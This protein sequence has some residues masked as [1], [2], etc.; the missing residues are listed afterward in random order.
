MNAN[1]RRTHDAIVGH[2]APRDIIW[3]D[4]IHMWNDLADEVENESGDRLSVTMNGHREVFRRGHDG[5]VGIED[6][7]RARHL[8]KATPVDQGHGSLY[9][10]TVDDE[11]AHL[12]EFDLDS[13]KVDADEQQVTDGDRRARRLRTT[14]RKRGRDDVA[15]LDHYYREIADAVK[16][17]FGEHRYVVLGHGHGKSD[18]AANF[19]KWLEKHENQVF[20]RIIAT[21]D[22]DLSAV[23]ERDIEKKAQELARG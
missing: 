5:R 1:T 3:N 21:G 16:K 14:E 15:D 17:D 12:Y 4:F 18:A 20:G 11:H 8:L 23:N 10:L 13:V 19:E 22:A 7:E 2:P 9:V 6:I